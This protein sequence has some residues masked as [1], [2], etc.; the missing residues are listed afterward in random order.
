MVDEG[1]PARKPAELPLDDGPRD[2][3]AVDFASL[4]RQHL[5]FVFRSVRR[6]GVPP[7]AVDDAVQDVF[8]VVHRRLRDFGGQSSLR[9]WLFGIVLRVVRDHRRATGRRGGPHAP[10]DGVRDLQALTP[11]PLD[12][13]EKGEANHLLHQFLDGLDDDKRAVFVMI[14]VEQMTVPEVAQALEANIDTI[15][16]R[17]RAARQR[18]EE[19]VKRHRARETR[20]KP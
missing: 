1:V 15:Y 9:T 14:E 13:A 12:A 3:A 16:S 7:A 5:A 19:A 8:V 4:Y 17:L 10:I 6:L 2:G 11:S 18:F 20:R